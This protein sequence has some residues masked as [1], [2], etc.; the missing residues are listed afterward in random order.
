MSISE[1]THKKKEE[2][3]SRRKRERKLATSPDCTI[4]VQCCTAEHCTVFSKVLEN[5]NP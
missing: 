5:Y 4:D 3:K 1:M 2:K